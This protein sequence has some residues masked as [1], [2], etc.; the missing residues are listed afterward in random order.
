[1]SDAWRMLWA[2]S[3]RPAPRSSSATTTVSSPT[4]S[5]RPPPGY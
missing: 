5:P 2:G 4:V 1:M 3:S